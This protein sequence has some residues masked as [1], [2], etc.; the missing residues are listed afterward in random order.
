MCKLLC[1]KGYQFICCFVLLLFPCVNTACFGQTVVIRIFNETDKSPLRNQQVLILGIT[2]KVTSDENVQREMTVKPIKYDLR[3]LTDGNGEA[4]FE[5]P[6]PAPEYFYVR[7]VLSGPVWDCPCAVRVSTEELM[8]KGLR[9]RNAEADR[10][11][12]QSPVQPKPGQVL[13]SLRPTPLWE[14]I[15]YPIAK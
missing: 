9:I 2:G 12:I 8:Q 15:L 1:L 5:L 6:K 10:S 4:Q 7:A 11:H 14:R 3:L 13:F